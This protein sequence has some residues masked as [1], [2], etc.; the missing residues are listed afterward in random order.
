MKKLS[1]ILILAFVA[2]VSIAQ[3]ETRTIQMPLNGTYATYSNTADTLV[4][5]G[6]D[7]IDYIFKYSNAFSIDKVAVGFQVDTISG[8]DNGVVYSLYGKEFESSTTWTAIIAQDT[9]ADV[10]GLNQYYTAKMATIATDKSYLH[11]RLRLFMEATSGTGEKL[12]IDK[13]ELKTYQK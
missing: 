1:I 3:D 6:Q 9:T 4:D 5:A 10:A 13:V 8:A 11:L 12:R 2:L 7:S